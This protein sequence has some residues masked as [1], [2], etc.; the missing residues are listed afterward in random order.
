MKGSLTLPEQERMIETLRE[1]AWIED[2]PLFIEI[3]VYQAK[4]SKMICQVLNDE[5]RQ[6]RMINTD[7]TA[8]AKKRWH[9]RCTGGNWP[10]VKRQYVEGGIKKV[11]RELKIQPESVTWLFLDGCHCKK[12]CSSDLKWSRDLIRTGGFLLVHDTDP[13]HMGG[14]KDQ[15][16]HDP[17]T[18]QGFGVIP[19]LEEA[20]LETDYLLQDEV[21]G[22]K[23]GRR[24]QRGGMR[25]Y[26]RLA[27]EDR[28][29]PSKEKVES[30][31]DAEDRA[32]DQDPERVQA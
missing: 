27:P 25:V 2:N 26:R 16:Y 1:A 10:C 21:E 7:I 3:G 5:M 28:V 9:Q 17:K 31:E 14:P 20:R 6:A 32:G 30:G 29:D 8:Q 13:G 18:P 4:T 19:A 15:A 11:I 22:V 23:G 12:C 24:G